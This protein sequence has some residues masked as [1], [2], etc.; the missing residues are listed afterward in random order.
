MRLCLLIA[1]CCS[2]AAGP[3]SP[4]GP[5]QQSTTPTESIAAKPEESTAARLDAWRQRSLDQTCVDRLSAL[6]SS[7]LSDYQGLPRCGRVDAEASLGGSGAEPSRFEQFGEYRVY[8]HASG[9]FFVWFLADDIRVIQ[10]VSPHLRQPLIQVLGEPEDKIPSRLSTDWEQWVY[11]RR[12]LS[13]HVKRG[14]GEPMTFFAFRPT[15]AQ[16]FAETDIAK[17]AKGESPIEDLK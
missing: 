7:R 12:G 10:V 17:V 2:C 16:E 9:S 6:A 14:T 8:R 1:V 5:A 15:T 13:A 3:T 11:A 4:S